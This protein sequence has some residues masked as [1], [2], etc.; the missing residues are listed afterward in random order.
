M[1][2]YSR[3]QNLLLAHARRVEVISE[4]FEGRA[5]QPGFFLELVS[6]VMCLDFSA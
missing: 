5:Q 3:Q 4:G 2:D 1:A 6:A